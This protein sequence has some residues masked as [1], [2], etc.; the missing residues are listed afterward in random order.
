M[1]VL[2][3]KKAYDDLDGIVDY[4]AGLSSEAAE[5]IIDRIQKAVLMLAEFPNVGAKIDETGLRR[6]V[7][8]DTPYV[9]FYRVHSD[10]V[11]IRGI[12]HSSQRH[13]LE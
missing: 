2:W 12:F 6:L 10:S 3:G 9:I 1:T 7:V 13:F 8:S 5:N 11:H 4:I